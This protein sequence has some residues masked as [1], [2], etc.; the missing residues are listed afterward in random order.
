MATLNQKSSN[1]M[2]Y[3][4]I[5]IGVGVLILIIVIIFLISGKPKPVTTNTPENKKPKTLPD[6]PIFPIIPDTTTPGPIETKVIKSLDRFLLYYK[7]NYKK[8]YENLEKKYDETKIKYDLALSELPNLQNE[9]EILYNS[10]KSI[11]LPDTSNLEQYDNQIIRCK[12]IINKYDEGNLK[13]EELKAI[14][15]EIKS[16]MDSKEFIDMKTFLDSSKEIVEKYISLKDATRISYEK[17]DD[18]YKKFL[19]SYTDIN[20]ESILPSREYIDRIETVLPSSSELQKSLYK[21]NPENV[22][23][24][25]EVSNFIIEIRGKFNNLYDKLKTQYDSDQANFKE[26]AY[27]GIIIERIKKMIEDFNDILRKFEEIIN[28]IQ[29]E[30]NLNEETRSKLE[31]L[32]NKV[33][34]FVKGFNTVYNTTPSIVN[35]TE[36]DLSKNPYYNIP[37]I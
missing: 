26:F 15:D 35:I 23:K 16:I 3:I 22:A 33:D 6:F 4:G 32:R 36:S 18:T 1:K 13:E 19:S 10:N 7:N 30:L 21:D 2:V 17:V 12:G 8:D 9:T 31:S 25:N 29:G 34:S 28:S 27:K 5:G 37:S 20:T 24:V 14:L 11:K